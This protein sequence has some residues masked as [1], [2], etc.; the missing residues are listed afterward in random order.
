MDYVTSRRSLIQQNGFAMSM[1]SGKSMRPLIWGGQHCVVVVPLEREPV[2]GD[3]LMF[4]QTQPDG[5][6]RNIV[7]RL[8]EIRRRYDQRIYVTRGD[9][10]LGSERVRPSEVIGR[11]VE[12]HRIS[13]YRPWHIIPSGKISVNDR[14]YRGYTRVWLAIWPVRRIYYLIRSYV[15][16]LY[17]RMRSIL[18]TNR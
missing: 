3:I 13:G 10:C 14:A 17:S 9:N 16:T 12:I 7:H 5:K 8:I 15:Y 6:E 2:I 1:T 18:K 11:V 4:K